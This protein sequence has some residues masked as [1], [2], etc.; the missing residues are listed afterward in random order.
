M[1][2]PGTELTF[3]SA[4]TPEM[5]NYNIYLFISAS[6]YTNI[7]FGFA[8]IAALI[9]LI[10]ERKSLKKEGWLFM[11]IILFLLVS[12]VVL[13][14]IYE[15]FC[16]S[17]ALFYNDLTWLSS[18]IKTNIFMRY[19]NNANTVLSGIS[20]LASVTIIAFTIWKPLRLTEEIEK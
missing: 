2:M 16:I 1:F 3:K 13:Y 20:Y 17:R 7:A 6:T 19:K 11:S 14:N 10:T 9:I 4:Y 5:I 12:P 15:D 8:I 18:D